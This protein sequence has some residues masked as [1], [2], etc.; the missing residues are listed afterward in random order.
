MFEV[1]FDLKVVGSQPCGYQEDIWSEGTVSAEVL[2]QRP[3][4][5]AGGR[6]RRSLWLK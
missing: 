4:S 2:S 3:G 6:M 1:M 5:I